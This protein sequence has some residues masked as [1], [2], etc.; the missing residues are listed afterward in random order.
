MFTPIA[1]HVKEKK[2]FSI[3]ISKILK[4]KQKKWSGE[5]VNRCLN[6]KCGVNSLVGFSRNV[7]YGNHRADGHRAP[8]P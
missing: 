4:T 6:I 5:M 3:K 7:F 1:I 2:S 8:G